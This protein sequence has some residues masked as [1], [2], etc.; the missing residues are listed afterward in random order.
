MAAGVVDGPAA[1]CP[2]WPLP[3]RPHA[4][5]RSRVSAVPGRAGSRCSAG[6]IPCPPIP[7]AVLPWLP[8]PGHLT[9]ADEQIRHGG[10]CRGAATAAAGPPPSCPSRTPRPVSGRRW[11]RTPPTPWLSTAAPRTAVAVH[12]VGV[13]KVGVWMAGVWMAD[14]AAAGGYPPLQESVA[15]PASAGRVP[16]PPVGIGQLA[17]EPDAK[18]G[19]DQGHGRSL[20]RQGFLGA[21]PAQPQA[22]QV[23]A[24]PAGDDRTG[25]RLRVDSELGPGVG[26]QA[27]SSMV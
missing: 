1:G 13:Q 23:A 2:A 24:L 25:G 21:Q 9:S 4:L 10:S 20:H 22:Q 3:Q 27:R 7:T 19:A 12:K 5:R 6:R 26:G 11:N 16:P 14:T 8:R 15:C 17:A 18:L